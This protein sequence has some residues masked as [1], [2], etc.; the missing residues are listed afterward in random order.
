MLSILFMMLA[1]VGVISASSHREAPLISNDP[2]AD[3]VDVYAFRSPDNPDMITLIATYIPFQLPQGGPNYYT[4]GENIRYE[5][6]VDNDASV[7]GDEVTYRFTFNIVNEDPTTFFNIRLGKQ[8]QKATYTLERSMDGGQTFEVIIEDGIVPP[9]NIGNRSIAGGAGL[10]SDYNTLWNN[11]ITSAST[12][13]TVF[14]GPSD[15]PFF[16]DLG[17]IFDLGDAPRQNG[18]PVDGVAC[19]NT[20]T[21]AIQVPISTLL[22]TGAPA[23]PTNILD[24]DYVIG[25]WASASRPA[26]TTLSS[27]GDPTVS[28]DWVQVSR[29]GMPLTNE[30]VIPIGYK[31]FWNSITPYDELGE[32]EMDEF[33]YNPELAL[34][35]DDSQFGGAVPAFSPLRIQSA[36]LG[37]FDF[38]NGADGVSGLAGGDLTGTAFEVYGDLLLIPGKP[39]SV[40]LWPIFHTGVPNAIPYQLATGKEGNPLAAGKP[41]INNFLP[42][43]GDMLRLNMAVPPTPRD[44]PN[45]SSLGL[46]QAAAIGLTVAPFNTTA[47]LEFIPNMDGFPNGRRLEDDVTRIELQAVGGVV[48]AAIG[49][50]YDDY[51]PT[52]SPSPVTQD[53]LNVLTYTTGV[54][55]NDRAF[56]TSFPY[57]AQPFSGTG[58][59]SGEVIEEVPVINVFNPNFSNDFLISARMTGGNQVPAVTTDAIGVATVTFNDDYT[60]A[61]IN[62]TV[63]NL[64]SGFAGV[65]IHEAQPGETGDV[66]FNLSADYVKGRVQSI[67]D[68]TREDVANFMEGNYYINLHT[69]NNPGG[70]LRGNL[71]LEAAESFITEL[72]GDQ[73]VPSLESDGIGLAALHYTPNTNVLEIN[74]LTSNL[75][76][77]ITGIHLHNGSLGENGD[78]VENLSTSLDGN[79]VSVKI[80]AGDYIDA[81]RNEDIYINVH[82]EANPGGEVRGQLVG[83]AGLVYDT[84]M[85]GGQEVPANDAVSFGL[86]IGELESDLSG[87]N[88]AILVDK[89][90]GDITGAHF[91]N[92]ALGSNGDVVL[93]LT[94]FITGSFILTDDVLAVDDAFV[95][96]FLSGDLYLNVHTEMYPAGEVRGQVYRIARDGYAYDLCQDQQVDDVTDAGD[97]SG[98]GMF[99]FNRDFDEAHMMVVANELSSEFQGSHIHNGAPEVAGPVV[100]N[101]TDRWNDNGTFFYI[102]DEF[103]SDLANLIQSGNAYVNVHTTNNPGGEVRGQI[104]KTPNCPL[105]TATIEIDGDLSLEARIFPNPVSNLLTVEIQGDHQLYKNTTLVI[106]DVS[107]RVVVENELL[108]AISQIDTETL[109]DGIYVLTLKNKTFVHSMKFVKI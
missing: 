38:R 11:A 66:I 7:S 56:L 87:M 61:T 20:S 60:T 106:T 72:G 64:S 102:T 107:G 29:L 91:H 6:H 14:A 59:C 54:E 62:A 23:I 70:E 97:A 79:S 9:N 42:N 46:I 31:D 52:T 50:W 75:T 1:F 35:M 104:V 89:S 47:D 30:V 68:V 49:L 21:I 2:L 109:I 48:L 44:D 19:Y 88:T 105:S 37:A 100:F 78:V 55:K 43:G 18:T 65:H 90:S 69:E 36:S 67:I 8:N 83:T 86:A 24:P 71:N 57:V 17:G 77:P 12:G 4:F 73:E 92:A 74:I 80:Q 5:I 41:F 26:M 13:E 82:T 22:K 108:S 25:V 58:G 81:L 27:T 76:G 84:W 93:N 98:S 32:T 96:S 15:D 53:L 101:L 103:T 28:G 33:F 95:S 40:D 99:A 34:Y 39:R 63:S 85:T 10:N 94:E 16:V 45:F 51:D 3:N